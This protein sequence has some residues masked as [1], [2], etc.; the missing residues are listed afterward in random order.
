VTLVTPHLHLSPD[1]SFF[2][3]SIH[4]FKR[5]RASNVEILP[6]T[7]V[8]RIE[9][10][11]AILYE[12]PTGREWKMEANAV[13]LNTGRERAGDLWSYFNGLVTDTREIGDCR[14]A[15]GTIRDAIVGGYEAGSSV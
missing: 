3:Q 10:E 11:G 6:L 13:V 7:W 1:L 2:N 14:V 9:P 4:V 15:G 5:L 8:K 12:I